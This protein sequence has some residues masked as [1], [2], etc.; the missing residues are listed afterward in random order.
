MPRLSL[1]DRFIAGAKSKTAQTDFFDAKTLGL[2]LRVS[3]SGVKSW[4][5]FFTSPKTGKRAR[6]TL[7]RYPRTTLAD[8]RTRALEAMA[9]VDAGV[10]PRDVSGGAMTVQQ[11]VSSY[12]EKH[13][14]PNLRSRKAVERRLTKNALP[15]IGSI[16]VADLHKRDI[17]RVLD[18]IAARGCAVEGARVFQDLRA[19]C[20]WAVS[21]GD[22][23]HSPLDGMDPPTSA[24]PRERVLADDEVA[25]LWA[26]L[27]EALP[28]SPACQ[29]II[30]LCLLTAQRVGEVAGMH[31]DELDLKARLWTIPAAR[32]KNGYAHAVPLTDAALAVMESGNDDGMTGFA[33]P[34]AKGN[35]PLPAHAVS[36][37]IR[38]AQDRFGLP[39][40]TAHDLRRTAV[41]GMAKLG[42][43]PIV[44]GHVINHRSV[45][46]AGTTL[47]VYSQYDYGKEKSEALELWADRLVGIVGGAKLLPMRK[48]RP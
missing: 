27:P 7:G 29:S 38:L 33:F 5:L 45:T 44:L 40:W 16:A 24:K 36:K 11:L 19:M 34:D 28:R 8:A 26:A 41:T 17:T 46:K 9:H 47:S 10:D 4:N 39:Q 23:D 30:K 22:L 35:G 37:T 43:S 18:R 25:Q 2:V 1:T 13:V 31:A 48:A 14:R 12:L 6:T 42:V 3:A 32:S 20:R 15:L 21:R